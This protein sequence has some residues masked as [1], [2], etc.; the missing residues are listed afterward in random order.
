MPPRHPSANECIPARA[1][2][3]TIYIVRWTPA[4]R[5]A[6]APARDAFWGENLPASTLAGVYRLGRPEYLIEVEVT[7]AARV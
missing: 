7:V 5:A 1:V 4:L 3:K 2:E 6:V